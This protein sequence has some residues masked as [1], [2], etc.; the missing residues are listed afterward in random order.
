MIFGKS[1]AFDREGLPQ[2]ASATYDSHGFAGAESDFVDRLRSGDPEAFDNL[3]TRYSADIYAILFRITENP[4]EAA[5]LTQETFL[6]ALKSIRTFRG[7]SELKTWLFRI[8]VN[9]SRNRFRWWKRRKKDSTVSLDAP[10]GDS[11][12]TVSDLI[13]GSEAS[14]EDTV[15][16]HEREAAIRKALLELPE[17]Y[18]EAI[19]LCDIEGLSYE[20]IA[21]ALEINIG[22]VKSRIARGRDE[23]RKRLKG[24]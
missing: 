6:S 23:L 1:I 5:D 9:H 10:I 22:T 14:A 16:R 19:V 12:S 24:F 20:E 18:R 15:L 2:V 8:A 17:I 7:E 4:E 13:A 21:S 11:N 3:I